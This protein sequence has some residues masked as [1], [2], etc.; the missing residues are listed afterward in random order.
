MPRDKDR[1]VA[2]KDRSVYSNDEKKAPKV[3]TITCYD[4]PSKEYAGRKYGLLCSWC[5][6]PLI[7][8]TGRGVEVYAVKDGGVFHSSLPVAAPSPATCMDI[9]SERV[10]ASAATGAAD[11]VLAC[12]RERVEGGGKQENINPLTVEAAN[13]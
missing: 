8:G 6:L 4:G 11:E 1:N 12:C 10:K 13:E 9:Y 2:G 7:K 3:K 5:G